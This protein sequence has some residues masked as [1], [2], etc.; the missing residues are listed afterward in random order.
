MVDTLTKKHVIPLEAFLDEPTFI[1]RGVYSK[2]AYVNNV[3]TDDICGYTY[4]CFNTK[5]LELIRV[6]VSQSKPLV[7]SDEI[8]DSLENGTPIVV[9]FDE[10]MVKVYMP[11]DAKT[12]AE[13]ITA[14]AITIVKQ[15]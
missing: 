9:E 7:T 6:T 11:R 10:A 15:D 8:T 4:E 12:F 5:T 14:K 1:L 2:R 13:S 3:A